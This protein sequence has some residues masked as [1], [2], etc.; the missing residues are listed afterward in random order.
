MPHRSYCEETML[1]RWFF[2]QQSVLKLTFLV[3]L[4]QVWFQNRRAKWRKREKAKDGGE[5]G[6]KDSDNN[7]ETEASPDKEEKDEEERELSGDMVIK[8]EKVTVEHEGQDTGNGEKSED[9]YRQE[10]TRNPA[11]EEFPA[12]CERFKGC[13]GHA[14][15]DKEHSNFDYFEK[16]RTSSIAALRRRAKEHEVLLTSQN[17][18]I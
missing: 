7:E 17:S 8:K 11:K 5:D 18:V 3:A 16:I 14:Y 13:A 9:G 10:D 6:Q 12:Q 15:S 1:L 4:S 2:R